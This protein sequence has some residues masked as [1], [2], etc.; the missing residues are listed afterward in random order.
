MN[1]ISNKSCCSTPFQNFL[2]IPKPA[3]AQRPRLPQHIN[4]QM[5]QARALLWPVVFDT[6]RLRQCVNTRFNI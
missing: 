3:E 1:S 4:L 2:S 5:L 6:S